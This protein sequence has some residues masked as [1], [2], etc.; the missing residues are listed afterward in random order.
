ME[1]KNQV[2]EKLDEKIEEKL[3]IEMK[4]DEQDEQD[5]SKKL[6][7]FDDF[8]DDEED[9]HFDDLAFHT[10][11]LELL[12]R[13]ENFNHGYISELLAKED[14]LKKTLKEI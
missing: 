2:N 14:Q 4:K 3:K 9:A 10:H 5:K 12:S 7:Q 1:L 13:S 8:S 6:S 11:N